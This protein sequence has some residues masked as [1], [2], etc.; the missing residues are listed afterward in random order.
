MIRVFAEMAAKGDDEAAKKLYRMVSERIRARMLP[1]DADVIAG[2]FDRLAA[3]ESPARVFPAKSA[4]RPKKAGIDDID[5][6]WIVRQNLQ[7][8]LQPGEVYRGV[9][10]AH[11]LGWRTV[12]NIY[13]KIKKQE[14]W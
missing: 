4:G 13:S 1:E 7:R 11:G 14:G 10:K 2:W 6:A 3:G 12:A 8:G 5:I 9:G